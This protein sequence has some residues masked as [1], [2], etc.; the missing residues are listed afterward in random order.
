MVKVEPLGREMGHKIVL[1]DNTIG[2]RNDRIKEACVNRVSNAR[3]SII[4]N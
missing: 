2:C 3:I 1:I 4:V